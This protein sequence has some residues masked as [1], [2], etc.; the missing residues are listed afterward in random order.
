V[1]KLDLQQKVHFYGTANLEQLPEL[2]HSADFYLS[3]SHSD[4]SSVS[5]ME[6]LAC[7]LPVIVSD[8]P[9]NQEW[10]TEGEQG[11]LF[12][13]G[14]AADFSNKILEAV[15]KVNTLAAIKKGNRLLA[16]KRADW[17]KNFAVLLE[18]YDLAFQRG[19]AHV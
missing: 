19:S 10:V 9:G 7:G 3:A 12:K 4:G 18:A 11:W 8:I 5:L 17:K 2:Y 1:K 13:D 15:S 6:A 16:E 14:E